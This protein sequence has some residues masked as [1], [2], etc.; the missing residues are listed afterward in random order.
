MSARGAWPLRKDDKHKSSRVHDWIRH[1]G[2]NCVHRDGVNRTPIQAVV[3]TSAGEG[4][5]WQDVA[6][7]KETCSALEPMFVQRV[8]QTHVPPTPVPPGRWV[9]RPQHL[10]MANGSH[11]GLV[12]CMPYS[13]SMGVL[14]QVEGAVLCSLSVEALTCMNSATAKDTNSDQRAIAYAPLLWSG[15]P[16]TLWGLASRC[17]VLMLH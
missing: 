11:A 3:A 15:I 9:M 1:T 4:S 17:A 6:Q 5:R 12:L 8:T 10:A 13:I 16:Q 7:C 2:L 14:F